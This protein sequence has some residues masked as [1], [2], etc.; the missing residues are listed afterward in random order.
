METQAVGQKTQVQK[1]KKEHKDLTARK[2][3]I[4]DQYNERIAELREKGLE[5][6][7]LIERAKSQADHGFLAI[8]DKMQ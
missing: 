4:L 7:D 3:K 8:L 5:I 1:L 6:R 2:L